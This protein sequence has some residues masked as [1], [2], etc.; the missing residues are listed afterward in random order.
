M[1]SSSASGSQGPKMRALALPG[2]LTRGFAEGPRSAPS[3]AL[4]RRTAGRSWIAQAGA[5]RGDPG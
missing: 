4:E 1:T 3:A 5:R 2:A